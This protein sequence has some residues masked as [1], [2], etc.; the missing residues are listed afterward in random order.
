MTPSLRKS[1]TP[2]AAPP[3]RSSLRSRAHPVQEDMSSTTLTVTRTGDTSGASKSITPRQ[4]GP[5]ASAQTTRPH[6]APFVSPRAKPQSRLTCSSMKTRRWKVTKRL[7]SHF[8]IPPTAPR[9]GAQCTTTFQ[10]MDDVVEPTTNVIDDAGIFVGQHYHDFLNRQ[11]DAGGLAFWT[12]QIT[13]CGA[14]AACIDRNRTSVSTAFFVSIEFQQT[15]YLVFRFYKETFTDSVGRPRGMPRYREFLRDTQEIGRGVVV[16]V[17]NWE[18]QLETN[19]QEFAQRWVQRADFIAEFPGTMTA[20]QF[21]DKLFLNSEVTPTTAER[22]AAIAAFGAGN[23]AGRA[24]AL[25]SVADSGSVYNRQYNAAFVLIQYIGYL[26]RNPNDAPEPGLNYAG[27]DYWLNKM[28]QFSIPGEDVRNE[29]VA[30]G[31][32][33]RAEMVRAFIISLE[34]RGRFGP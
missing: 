27:Y 15:G 3:Q 33:Q 4:T 30:L 11:A 22:D 18:T 9:S 10:I 17:G 7:P 6:S 1:A 5:P 14:D 31:R 34:Y 24:A 25:R 32:I 12:G 29:Q 13:A 16:G 21:V 8:Q 2:P 23:V 28:N 26:R 20:A 19:K